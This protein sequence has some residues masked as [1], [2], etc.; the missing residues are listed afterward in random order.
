MN[1]QELLVSWL[2]TLSMK[3]LYPVLEN[4]IDD[5]KTSGN[6]PTAQHLARPAALRSRQS[7]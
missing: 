3:L 6:V 5:A 4:H 1:Q 7:W 2:T